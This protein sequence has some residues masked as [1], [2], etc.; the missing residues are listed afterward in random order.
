MTHLDE[1]HS[2]YELNSLK[3]I[4]EAMGV[5]TNPSI[6]AFL[7]KHITNLDFDRERIVR[8]VNGYPR[9]MWGY[10]DSPELR[11]AIVAWVEKNN[12]NLRGG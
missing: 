6:M 9:E 4:T 11:K 7:G 5:E 10:Y 3:G 1:R 8:I 2:R 12:L